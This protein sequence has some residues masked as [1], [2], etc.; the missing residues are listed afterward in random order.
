LRE[1]VVGTLEVLWKRTENSR[2]G[3]RGVSQTLCLTQNLT[4]AYQD[5]QTCQEASLPDFSVF[6]GVGRERR[7]ARLSGEAAPSHRFGYL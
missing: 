5:D 6:I 4:K 1:S 3:G 2:R 7:V